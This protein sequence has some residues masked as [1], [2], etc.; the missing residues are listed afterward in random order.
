MYTNQTVYTNLPYFQYIV[1][2][3]Y[4]HIHNTR[5]YMNKYFHIV[6]VKSGVLIS[7]T[8][9]DSTFF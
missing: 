9:I 2:I 1:Y 4:I 3:V 6:D 7:E 8:E 5:E